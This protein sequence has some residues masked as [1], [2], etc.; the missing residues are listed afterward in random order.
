MGGSIKVMNNNLSQYWLGLLIGTFITNR[1][2]FDLWQN[3]YNIIQK[4]AE[5]NEMEQRWKTRRK[6]KKEKEM[7]INSVTSMVLGGLF[8]VLNF[9]YG[10]NF[11]FV[12][13][14]R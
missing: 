5:E 8:V 3:C 7:K 4:E 12:D 2:S 13:D 6:S 9:I 14:Y 1:F 10:D 11:K